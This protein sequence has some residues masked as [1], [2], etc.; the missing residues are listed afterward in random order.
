MHKFEK[1]VSLFV[2]EHDTRYDSYV[3]LFN[4]IFAV[5]FA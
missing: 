5:A 3:L 4:G 2:A 1:T